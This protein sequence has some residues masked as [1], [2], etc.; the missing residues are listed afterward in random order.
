[1]KKAQ[2]HEQREFEIPVG[3]TMYGTVKVK[4]RSLKEAVEIAL[5]PDC[6]LPDGDYLDDSEV[7][8]W[9]VVAD[10]NDHGDYN[11]L[12]EDDLKYLAEQDKTQ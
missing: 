6:G 10:A 5:G 1:M 12:D 9:E 11:T 8:A 3:W 4:A 7:V 2:A